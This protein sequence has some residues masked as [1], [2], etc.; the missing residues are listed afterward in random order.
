MPFS[1]ARNVS[2]FK[3]NI[4]GFT[5]IEG[6]IAIVVLGV[7]A[8]ISAP[9]FL[10]WKAN[11]GAEQSISQLKATLREVQ[12]ESIRRSRSCTVTINDGTSPTI[13]A[14]PTQCL[15]TGTLTLTDMTLRRPTA[16]G[17]I[18]F[19][20]K[21]VSLDTD[22]STIVVKSSSSDGVQRCLVFAE[23]IG[24]IRT[25]IYNRADTTGTLEGSCT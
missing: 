19:D 2:F 5:L 20:M 1:N 24:L 8:S 18:T 17:T 21:G 9:S 6:L 15:P 11:V 3:P 23:P 13:T 14:T 10:A 22:V 7:L 12:Q 16:V 4:E 25:G